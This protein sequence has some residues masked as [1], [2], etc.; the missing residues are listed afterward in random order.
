MALIYPLPSFPEMFN[1]KTN[2]DD[3]EDGDGCIEQ[4]YVRKLCFVSSIYCVFFF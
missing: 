4:D 3:G 1:N 2:N